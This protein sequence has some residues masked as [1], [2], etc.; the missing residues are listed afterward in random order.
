MHH[1]PHGERTRRRGLR[2]LCGLS[3]GTAL[4][5]A[6]GAPDSDCG[7]HEGVVERVIDGDTVVLTS[8]EHIRYLLVD[9]PETSGTVGCYGPEASDFNRSLVEGKTVQL[10]YDEE[11]T[12][13]YDRLLAYVELE[14]RSVNELLLTRGLAC[15]LRIPPNGADHLDDYRELEDAAQIGQVG[16][17]GACTESPCD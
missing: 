12:D 17:W 1:H 8:G 6:C 15:V 2:L 9:T 14:G 7:P 3:L 11:C 16:L 4:G 5:L 13:R 10:T